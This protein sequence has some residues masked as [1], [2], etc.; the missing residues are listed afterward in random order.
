MNS[1]FKTVVISNWMAR[2]LQAVLQIYII[3]LLTTIL[4]L[5]EYAMYTLLVALAYWICLS[6]FGLGV[7]LQNFISECRA[8][9]KDFS[10]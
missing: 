4:N 5:D 2:I 8:K 10:P 6:D 3:R 1:S 7:S 9:E